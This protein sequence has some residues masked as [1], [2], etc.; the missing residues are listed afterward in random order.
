MGVLITL[1]LS[2]GDACLSN[3]VLSGQGGSTLSN[4]EV[5]DCSTI[6]YVGN[7]DIYGCTDSNACNYNLDATSDDGSCTLL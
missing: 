2:G 1:T 7:T 3:L 4:A 6:S 5:L